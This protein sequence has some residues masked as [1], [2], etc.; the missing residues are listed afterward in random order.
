MSHETCPKCSK[1][2]GP[3]LKSGY[4]ACMRC[5]WSDRPAT[6]STPLQSNRLSNSAQP[7]Q[8]RMLLSLLCHGSIFLSWAVV[9]PTIIPIVLF[10]V[11]NDSIVKAN[12]KEAINFQIWLWIVAILSIIAVLVM[13]LFIPIILIVIVITSV[14][15]LIFPILAIIQIARTPDE[16]AIYPMIQRLIP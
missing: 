8:T 4:Q 11:S 14:I 5:G 15:S 13:P 7:D 2:L 9:V 1:S 16:P 6:L 10:F 12:A 3:V